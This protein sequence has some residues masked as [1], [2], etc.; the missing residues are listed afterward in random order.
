MR[1]RRSE[2]G[3]SL[4]E[5]IVGMTV[6]LVVMSMT[7][8]IATQLVK[9]AVVGAA[10]GVS[11]ETAQSQVVILEQ[12]L[13][14]AVSPANA[15]TEYP[16]LSP[17]S[18]APSSTTAVQYAYDYFLELCTARPSAVA[19]T[20][21]TLTSAN[22]SCPQL[23][24]LTVDSSSCASSYNKCTL[25]VQNLSASG[26]PT[27]FTSTIFRCASTCRDDLGSGTTPPST[28]EKHSA[29]PAFPY[30][31]TYYSSDG[32]TQ[33]D[34][35]SASGVQSVHLDLQMLNVPTALASGTQSYTEISDAVWLA[36][37]ATPQT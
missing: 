28:H 13:H 4:P 16:S 35:S 1:R 18:G 34:G 32:T 9:Q 19:C 23:Y 2:G 7:Y 14:G 24:L 3:F 22:T 10:T 29:S 31:F 17:C 5:V 25:K 30:L 37:A 27:V 33:L 8:L 36:G 6:L 11:S 20:A 15:Q 12:Y 26:T 21:G